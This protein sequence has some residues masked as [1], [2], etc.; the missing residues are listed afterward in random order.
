MTQARLNETRLSV[1]FEKDFRVVDCS[2]VAKVVVGRLASGQSGYVVSTY[3]GDI[4]IYRDLWS[5][6]HIRIRSDDDI[7]DT[8]LV[9][10]NS[11]RGRRTMV[12][13]AHTYGLCRVWDIDDGVLMVEIETGADIISLHP[14][15][16]S[17]WLRSGHADVRRL[18]LN[19]FKLSLSLSGHSRGHNIRYIA[20]VP[21]LPLLGV[22]DGLGQLYIYDESRPH[23]G[24]AVYP[25]MSEKIYNEA[26]SVS[27]S[28]ELV[29]LVC[30]MKVIL[31]RMDCVQGKLDPIKG[32]L[33]S[34]WRF[35]S[36]LAFP[37]RSLLAVDSNMQVVELIS[38]DIVGELDATSAVS[39]G[40]R[41]LCQLSSG[42]YQEGIL[43]NQGRFISYPVL[44]SNKDYERC[45]RTIASDGSHIFLI[46]A[47]DSCS[48][49]AIPLG[50][51]TDDCSF[52]LE[53]PS[54]M[55]AG[56]LT[57]LDGLVL[58]KKIL[59]GFS[60]GHICCWV[61]GSSRIEFEISDSSLCPIIRFDRVE[62][63]WWVSL[64]SIGIISL[65]QQD[66]IVSRLQPNSLIPLLL[67][68]YDFEVSLVGVDSVRCRVYHHREPGTD[69]EET[70]SLS[71]RERV[72]TSV[73][74]PVVPVGRRDSFQL[75]DLFGVSSRRG[76]TTDD[77]VK[78]P[79]TDKESEAIHEVEIIAGIHVSN[80]FESPIVS[81]GCDG[82]K[83]LIEIL[84][85][86]PEIGVSVL[87]K[88]T[89]TCQGIYGFRGGPVSTLIQVLTPQV[90]STTR[91]ARWTGRTDF[92]LDLLNRE[93]LEKK[94]ERTIIQLLR[95]DVSQRNCGEI[96]N[97]RPLLLLI[98]LSVSPHL[99]PGYRQAVA[100]V[101]KEEAPHSHQTIF[102]IEF[103]EALLIR[104][105]K[106][107]AK[108]FEVILL[109]DAFP[110]V[111][112][113]I[114]NKALFH[115]VFCT[116]YN[117][118]SDAATD[119]LLTVG[120]RNMS[121]FAKRLSLMIKTT[122]SSETPLF[123]IKKMVDE[124]R[125][126]SMR[127]LP[128]LFE[129]VVLPCLDPMDYRVRK[130]S[131]G[132]VTEL[133]RTLNKHY[134]MTGFHQNKQK[135][136]LGTTQGQ[137]V[138]Y[139]IRSGTKWR[140]LEGHTG[141]ISAV[142]FDISGKYLCSYSATD[143]TVRVWHMPGSL[144]GA[145]GGGKCITVKQLGE[146]D[147]GESSNR[148]KHPFDLNYRINGVKIRWTSETDILLVRETGQGVQ[149]RI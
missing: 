99:L 139:D 44:R 110:F 72:P 61:A 93:G 43:I 60:N 90:N 105:K 142:G 120:Q 52:P 125:V 23:D 5:D 115:E 54:I 57:A 121:S 19:Q 2:D 101:D 89:R 17:V 3:S 128:L 138:V 147:T 77:T 48:V 35:A 137:V 111:R 124:Y 144:L 96:D 53:M 36:A 51:E 134:P 26:F 63:D 56:I 14:T 109:T 91:P 40:N 127:H 41:I 95:E 30:P 112:V 32:V 47:S 46:E 126:H 76:S 8:C 75:G 22:V 82:N 38:E 67:R 88:V 31:Y 1:M 100:E 21:D 104:I 33:G 140:V 114:K 118:L 145:G 70:W 92:L 135:F 113:F 103:I 94:T 71:R 84:S 74:V 15:L 10:S 37:A 64:N 6:P 79:A 27:F 68:R 73:P 149:I 18:C 83:E 122:H 108:R 66:R 50:L 146:T 11:D 39:C 16:E 29:A 123:L 141:A 132:P 24:K 20:S 136:A 129:T 78:P 4:L 133:F 117:E 59:A 45:S 87:S 80:F 69:Y 106:K 34:N 98:A 102:Y 148:I 9:T 131:V 25:L 42:R 13:V 81:M 119:L 58:S 65:M 28:A 62:K 86:R 55:Q 130:S 107:E 12:V 85:R 7:I 143:N 97:R 116:L 49:T